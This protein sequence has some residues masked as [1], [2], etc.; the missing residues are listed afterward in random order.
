MVPEEGFPDV[1]YTQP[2]QAS[3]PLSIDSEQQLNTNN[4]TL[5]TK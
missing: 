2:G 5:K 3:R 1:P 4:Q